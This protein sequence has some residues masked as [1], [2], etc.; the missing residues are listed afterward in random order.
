MST[1]SSISITQENGHVRSIYCHWDGGMWTGG[2]AETLIENYRTEAEVNALID[3]GGCSS[4]GGT[5]EDSVFYARDRGEELE[6]YIDNIP[7][8][9][10]N[11][12]FKDGKWFVCCPETNW[13]DVVLTN[14]LRVELENYEE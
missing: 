14:E 1:N 4:L 13:E 8:Q 11:Y 5:I 6:I 2:V 9:E 10:Y 7:E 3:Q 12:M